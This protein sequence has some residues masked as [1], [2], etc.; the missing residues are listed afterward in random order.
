MTRVSRLI[1]FAAILTGGCAEAPRQS[2][3]MKEPAPRR[4]S[5]TRTD[6]DVRRLH[7]CYLQPVPLP[8]NYPRGYQPHPRVFTGEVF[9]LNPSSS[10]TDASLLFFPKD[11][12]QILE[13]S[14]VI[15]FHAQGIKIAAVASLAEARASECELVLQLAPLVF[16]VE[17]ETTATVRI[18]YRAHLLAGLTL[19]FD[20]VLGV[21]VNDPRLPKSITSDALVF[22]VGNH[23]FNFQPQRALLALAASR[24]AEEFLKQV[25]GR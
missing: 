14:T 12:L 17:G 1:V 3:I 22:L 19:V 9:S 16:H 6:V 2:A 11:Y 5:I 15:T 8:P 7:T 23:E 20:T 13:S 18:L 10:L 25:S 24:T 21:D 4:T